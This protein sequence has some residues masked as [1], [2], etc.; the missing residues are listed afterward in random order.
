MTE[1]GELK[2]RIRRYLTDKGIYWA[3]I[4]AGPGSKPGD[5]DIVMC[6]DGRFVGIEAKAKKGIQS[7][8]QRKRQKEIE[9][10][11]G[12]YYIV[13]SME[14]IERITEGEDVTGKDE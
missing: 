10:S 8:I 4:Q 13:R 1:E 6:L 5:P 9:Q 3:N 7:D 12:R 14:D 11:K 2:T